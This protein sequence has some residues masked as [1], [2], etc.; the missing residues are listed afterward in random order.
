MSDADP[1]ADPSQPQPADD[2]LT[3]EQEEDAAA[4]SVD[5]SHLK[6]VVEALL[7]STDRPVS[8][9]RL[10]DASGA[11]DGRQV[12]RV[13]KELR[14]QYD[15]GGHAFAL[16]EIAGGFQILTRPEFAPWVGRLNSQQRQETLSKAALETLAVVA[17]RQPITRAEVDD[18]RGVQTGPLLRALAG[19]RLIKVVGRSEELGRPL[20]YGTTKHFLEVFGLRSVKDLPKRGDFAKLAGAGPSAQSEPEAAPDPPPEGQ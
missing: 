19:R 15:E 17:Y 5:L 8:S 2:D 9:R 14:R 3:S 11:A 16:E 6:A 4:D 10:A 7:F 12:R 18:I 20:L 1:A 13:L